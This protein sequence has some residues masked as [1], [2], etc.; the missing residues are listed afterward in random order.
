MYVYVIHKHMY[1]F[2]V[3]IT[4]CFPLQYVYVETLYNVQLV[5][6]FG[7]LMMMMMM[8]QMD[9]DDDDDFILF[10]S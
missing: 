8:I 2:T 7:L 1:V 9:E 3:Y 6:P 4:Y 10:A 5:S